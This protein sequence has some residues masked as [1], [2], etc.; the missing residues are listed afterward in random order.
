MAIGY[1]VDLFNRLKKG[2]RFFGCVP[3]EVGDIVYCD[4]NNP[5][6][7][8]EENYVRTRFE[9]KIMIWIV[10]IVF[11]LIGLVCYP[12]CRKTPLVYEI[13]VAIMLLVWGFIVTKRF[14]PVKFKGTDFFV[15]T[16]GIARL[17]FEGDRDRIVKKDI[18]LYADVAAFS[19]K[20]K[21]VRD[22]DGDDSGVVFTTKIQLKEGAGEKTK[23]KYHSFDNTVMEDLPYDKLTDI[24]CRFWKRAEQ[25]W[26]TFVGKL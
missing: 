25:E 21:F 3:R 26:Q 11:P 7:E 6:K 18:L 20:G 13:L 5:S 4:T 19:V 8:P 17:D 22:S 9:Q 12:I 23:L 15:G 2:E 10:S 24:E 14:L 1:S 16:R